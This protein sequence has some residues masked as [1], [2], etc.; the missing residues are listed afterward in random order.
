M[1]TFLIH[2]SLYLRSFILFKIV[3][4]NLK[5]FLITSFLT[6][7]VQ[8]TWNDG[9]RYTYCYFLAR[10][11]GIV[12]YSLKHSHRPCVANLIIYSARLGR[13]GRVK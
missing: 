2:F 7:F 1:V 10:P 8:M 4:L 12:N 3:K 9:E 6:S 5:F 11:K 13:K